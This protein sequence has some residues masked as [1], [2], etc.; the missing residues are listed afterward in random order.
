MLCTELLD[1]LHSV[2]CVNNAAAILLEARTLPL[3]PQLTLHT[4]LE[5]CAL[6]L[7]PMLTLDTSLQPFCQRPALGLSPFCTY[8]HWLRQATDRDAD[9]PA[10][11]PCL[12]HLCRKCS[13]M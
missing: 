13:L 5:A 12:S 9:L 2:H 1:N 8:A 11:C 6:P 3:G 10:T 4:Q 7:V